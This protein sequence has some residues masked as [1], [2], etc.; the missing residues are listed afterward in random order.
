MATTYRLLEVWS[1]MP[2]IDTCADVKALQTIFDRV[3]SLPSFYHPPNNARS[4]L[5]S[6]GFLA[7][8]EFITVDHRVP[9][10]RDDGGTVWFSLTLSEVRSATNAFLL[11]VAP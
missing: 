9:A 6:R 3:L 4:A 7:M 2:C 10:F 1:S 11:S 8:A 5:T